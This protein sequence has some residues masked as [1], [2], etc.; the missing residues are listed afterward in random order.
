MPGRTWPRMPNVH[1][2]SPTSKSDYR[3]MTSAYRRVVKHVVV[4][5][6]TSSSSATVEDG[7]VSLLTAKLLTWYPDSGVAIC[8]SDASIMTSHPAFLGRAI[9]SPLLM[10]PD[11]V[12]RRLRHLRGRR[13]RIC[14]RQPEVIEQV[15][16]GVALATK[17]CQYQF[18]NDKWNCTTNRRSLKRILMKGE[19]GIH[20]ILHMFLS[21]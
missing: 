3:N 11:R 5:R 10:D 13:S 20:V 15:H 1:L 18:R 14:R 4:C 19:S 12:C 8:R 9:G 6:L 17:E 21:F 2:T 16:R 7:G